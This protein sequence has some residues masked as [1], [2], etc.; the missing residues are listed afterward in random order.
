MSSCLSTATFNVKAE[1]LP[2]DPLPIMAARYHPPPPQEK[3]NARKFNLMKKK[4]VIFF[5][6]Q[7]NV[8]EILYHI[9]FLLGFG[10][11]DKVMMA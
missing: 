1:V 10:N 9:S 8:V 7:E 2:L 11:P 3:K 6:P 5:L 4:K